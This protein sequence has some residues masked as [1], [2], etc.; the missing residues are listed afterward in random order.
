MEGFAPKDLIKVSE[1]TFQSSG[2]VRR[3][4]YADKF[5]LT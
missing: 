3:T 2:G 4:G 5:K 1:G